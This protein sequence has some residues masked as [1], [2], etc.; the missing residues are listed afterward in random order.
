MIALT[1][2]GLNRQQKQ[3]NMEELDFAITQTSH[4]F[5]TQNLL[6]MQLSAIV[7]R[8]QRHI[9]IERK[10]VA[11]SKLARERWKY[12]YFWPWL[13]HT[14]NESR[15][16]L[17]SNGIDCIN[18]PPYS[19]DLNPIENLWA[20]LKRRVE[21]RC[22]CDSTELKQFLTEEWTATDPEYLRCLA[23]SMID[24]CKAVAACRG[25]KTKY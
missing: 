13:Y 18:F 24:R 3:Q 5:S 15:A 17:H 4:W 19:P 6:L 2:F 23:H 20:D 1:Q 10:F 11:N 21:L 25:F 12:I 14:S 9:S 16:W 22:P 7:S 8:I